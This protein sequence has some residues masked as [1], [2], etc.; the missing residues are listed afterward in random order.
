MHHSIIRDKNG[1][2]IAKRSKP[3]WTV[4]T[5]RENGYDPLA[6]IKLSESMI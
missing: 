1:K 5:L 4:K 2:R 6:V 3:E